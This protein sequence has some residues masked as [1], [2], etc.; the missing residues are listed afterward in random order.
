MTPPEID[1]HQRDVLYMAITARLTGV[2]DVC[3]EY[4]H[5]NFEAAQQLS[6][7]FSDDLRVLHDDLGW[8]ETPSES[9]QLNAPRDVWERTLSRIQEIAQ[10]DLRRHDER[11]SELEQDRQRIQALE[12]AC[13]AIAEQLAQTA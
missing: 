7:E 2:N 6:G 11:A 12:D 8:G 9:I 1:P 3:I 10:S 13:G 4:Q 5:D